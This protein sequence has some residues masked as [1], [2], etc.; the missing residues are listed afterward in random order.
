MSLDD[1]ELFGIEYMY[2]NAQRAL[3]LF[4][5]KSDRFTAERPPLTNPSVMDEFQNRKP[6]Q[7][8]QFCYWKVIYM[9]NFYLKAKLGW[10]FFK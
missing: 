1:E 7:Y 4:R 3:C 6:Y 2:G 10:N 9:N 8:L 5:C